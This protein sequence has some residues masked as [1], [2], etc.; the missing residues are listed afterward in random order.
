VA[1]LAMI[2][3]FHALNTILVYE[4]AGKMLGSPAAASKRLKS[5]SPSGVV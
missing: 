3:F 1:A 4:L 2:F 5:A